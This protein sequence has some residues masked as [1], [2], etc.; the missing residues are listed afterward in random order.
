MRHEN[1]DLAQ[2]P[3]HVRRVIAG[4]GDMH[5]ENEVYCLPR[6]H[7]VA[8]AECEACAHHAG[9]DIDLL[10]HRNYVLCRRLTVETA[11]AGVAA[12]P[13]VLR[14]RALGDAT[15]GEHTT[16]SEIM[17]ADVWCARED[18]DL[19]SLRRFLAE[20]HITGVPVVD[21]LGR[22][23]GVV[24]RADLLCAR[25]HD[26]FVRDVMERLTFVLPETAS[27][28]QA[29]ALMALEHI[30]R[31][32]IVTDDEKVAGLVSSIDVLAWLA[33]HDGYVVPR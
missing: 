29:A 9:A 24:S 26:A 13:A 4:N 3:V 20:R 27:I 30:H 16:V 10:H 22:C 23:I 18:L 6:G 31:I 33:R 14:R 15:A 32:P 19:A 17:T 21:A 12:R 25:E 7:S 8:V 28:S 11:R 5:S 2:L 1:D